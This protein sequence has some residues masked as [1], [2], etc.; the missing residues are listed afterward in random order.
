MGEGRKVTVWKAMF[1][2]CGELVSIGQVFAHLPDALE[3]NPQKQISHCVYLCPP[4][5]LCARLKPSF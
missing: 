2:S 4:S 3:Y 5:L 1:A